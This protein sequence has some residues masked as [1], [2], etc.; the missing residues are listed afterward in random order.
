M[1]N[2]PNDEQK[3]AA[4]ALCVRHS[5]TG[6]CGLVDDVVVARLLATREAA[7]DAEIARLTS[8]RDIAAD[9]AQKTLEGF[10]VLDAQAKQL[11]AL[12]TKASK[13]LRAMA[14]ANGCTVPDCKTAR[15]VADEID[16]ALAPAT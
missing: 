15:D 3:Q 7:K 4:L 8:E 12:L 1:S 10:N 11:H 2:E 6:N 9:F 5:K 13:A 14:C 16:K